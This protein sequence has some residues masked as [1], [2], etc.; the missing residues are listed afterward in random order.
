M[1]SFELID[2][3]AQAERTALAWQRTALTAM[4]VAALLIRAY[5]DGQVWL[6]LLLAV[7]AAL[8]IMIFIPSR[9]RYVLGTVSAGHSPLSHRTVAVSAIAMLTLIVGFAVEL[10]VFMR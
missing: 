4:A 1:R 2:I 10:L 9:Y 3:G 5:T 7:A 6:G 8:S